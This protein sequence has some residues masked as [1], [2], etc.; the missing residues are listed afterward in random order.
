MAA[1]ERAYSRRTSG[2]MTGYVNFKYEVLFADC[3][4]AGGQVTF[5]LLLFSQ[6]APETG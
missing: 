4:M 5:V 2:G 6:S 3:A 1:L